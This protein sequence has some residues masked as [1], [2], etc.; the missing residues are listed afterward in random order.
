MQVATCRTPAEF[1]A[2]TLEYRAADPL[3][4]N[5]MATVAAGAASHPARY[6]VCYW[7]VVRDAKGHVAGAAIHTPPHPV[8]LGPMPAAS[9]KALARHLGSTGLELPSLVGIEQQV[10]AFIDEYASVATQDTRTFEV[11]RRDVLYDVERLVVPTVPGK[12]EVATETDLALA[13]SWYADFSEEIDGV[14]RDADHAGREALRAVLGEGRLYWWRDRGQVVSMAAHNVTIATPGASVTRVGPV[15][16]PKSQ[17]RHGYAAGVSAAVTAELLDRGSTVML[18][19]DE[20][21]A[22]SNGVYQSLGYR[23]VDVLVVATPQG[24]GAR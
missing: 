5:V 11:S 7:W 9:V 2:E 16:T 10:S 1:F 17:R 23:R 14:R 22:T 15:F 8:G 24:G 20:A 21:N 13:E 3:R 19:A 12:A 4:T 18:F 6:E